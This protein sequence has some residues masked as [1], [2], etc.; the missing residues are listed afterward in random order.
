[1][2]QIITKVLQ[3]G[4]NPFVLPS[5]T[6]Q[7]EILF[8]YASDEQLQFVPEP[9]QYIAENYQAW[10][11][12]RTSLN[13]RALSR[14]DPQK[15]RI[16]A[17]AERELLKTVLRRAAAGE[18]RWVLTLFPTNA[19]A[20]DAEMSLNDYE[21]F[22]Y[23]ACMPD[24]ND[25]VGYWQRLSARQH[26]IVDWLKNKHTVHLTSKDTDLQ[27][28]IDGRTFENCDGRK[29][30]P[31]GEVFTGPVEDSVEGHVSFSY[32]TIYEGREVS[33]V[34]LWFQKGKVVKASAEKNEQVLLEMLD[35]DEG[36]RYL[37]EFAI[38]TNEG[39][40]HFTREILFDEK[41]SGSFHIALG[42]G[43]PETGSKNESSIHWD[44]ICDMRDGSEITV[45][46]KQFYRNGTFVI[47]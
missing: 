17:Q 34:K 23:Q 25:P 30:M 10:I 18:L 37:G 47:E 9:F 7:N 38:G 20:Q 13:T 6:E 42:A 39:I 31:D 22:V 27:F 44:M 36:A 12:I 45:D 4:G 35:T 26:R 5:L 41:I 43:L 19:L 24:I 28:S 21:R 1:M 46:N 32:P 3:A 33:G 40:T 11:S 8:R 14:V 29:N 16:R 2:N 15:S